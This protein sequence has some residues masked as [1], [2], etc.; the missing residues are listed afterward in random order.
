[1]KLVERFVQRAGRHGRV[2]SVVERV[3]A[4]RS[5]RVRPDEGT[6]ANRE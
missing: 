1:M 3:R 6:M 4:R 5:N 2:C